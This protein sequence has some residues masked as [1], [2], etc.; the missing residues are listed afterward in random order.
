MQDRDDLRWSRYGPLLQLAR[1]HQLTV[2]GIDLPVA[3][4]RR[5]SR[6]GVDGLTSIEQAALPALDDQHL[7]VEGASIYREQMI[8]RLKAAHCGYG[9]RAYLLRLLQ[10]WEARNE[11]M[12]RT[13]ATAATKTSGDDTPVLVVVGG[14]HVRNGEGVVPR[15][16][17]HLPDAQ[18]LI[19]SFIDNNELQAVTLE[20]SQ[21]PVKTIA[22]SGK[23]HEV[24]W[25]TAALGQ[26][27][28]DACKAFRQLKKKA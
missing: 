3:L 27:M 10:N 24:L 22:D 7:G 4:R 8:S 21:H 16:A 18:Q 20:R 15:L 23:H 14:Q 11:T 1:E 19:V 13:I 9:S 5:V 17:R 6:V 12:A 25:A 26:S 2:F 28:E